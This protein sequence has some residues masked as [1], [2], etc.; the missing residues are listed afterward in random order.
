MADFMRSTTNDWDLEAIIRGGGGSSA[1]CAAVQLPPPPAAF[2]GSDGFGFG[3]E[4]DQFEYEEGVKGGVNELEELYKPFVVVDDQQPKHESPRSSM[5]TN[6]PCSSSFVVFDHDD[7]VEKPK[8]EIKR[9]LDLDLVEKDNTQ[10]RS[11]C[12]RRL[13]DWFNYRALIS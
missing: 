13:V 1:G 3:F 2:L 7:D 5:T 6:S 4:F 8:E 9:P 10:A 11:T 12:K